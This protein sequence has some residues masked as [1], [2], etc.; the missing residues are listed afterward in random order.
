VTG[1]GNGKKKRNVYRGKGRLRG[2][3][4]KKKI[5]CEKEVGLV[6]RKTSL[7]V[8]KKSFTIWGGSGRNNFFEGGEIGTCLFGKRKK[9]RRGN[10]KNV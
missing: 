9:K 8:E 7:T 4:K 2:K 1:G 6:V 10:L 5:L 3:K